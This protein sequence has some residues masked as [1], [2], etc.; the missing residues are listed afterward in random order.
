MDSVQISKLIELARTSDREISICLFKGEGMNVKE[1][2]LT[3]VERAGVYPKCTCVIHI[4]PEKDR[5]DILFFSSMPSS[6]DIA[7]VVSN[8]IK[9]LKD[10]VP[11]SDISDFQD[12]VF[13]K[14]GYIVYYVDDIFR[15]NDFVSKHPVSVEGVFEELD[16]VLKDKFDRI[17]MMVR[18]EYHVDSIKDLSVQ[19]RQEIVSTIRDYWFTFLDSIG[20]AVVKRD[21]T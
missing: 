18:D 20:V 21:I 6:R 10:G 3:S 5:E 7:I 2:A 9:L 13:H 8:A 16:S 17:K 15:L 14:N 11:I 12:M 19:E 1:G 4:H